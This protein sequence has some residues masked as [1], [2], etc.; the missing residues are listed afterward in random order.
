MINWRHEIHQYPEQG[1]AEYQTSRKVVE[2]LRSFEIDVYEGIGRTGIVGILKCGNSSKAIGLHADIDAL[3]IH[4]KIH[5]CVFYALC[6][7]K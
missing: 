2:L 4:E 5:F 3:D 1:F 7:K 6:F